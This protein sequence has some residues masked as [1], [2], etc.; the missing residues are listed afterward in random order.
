[1]AEAEAQ[2]EADLEQGLHTPV[3][4]VEEAPPVEPTPPAPDLS[5]ENVVVEY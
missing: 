2:A 3:A 5:G 1:M 4:I